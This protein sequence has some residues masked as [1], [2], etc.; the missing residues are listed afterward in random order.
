MKRE[1]MKQRK[2]QSIN[3]Q[4]AHWY[5]CI[6]VLLLRSSLQAQT[7]AKQKHMHVGKRVKKMHTTHTKTTLASKRHMYVISAHTQ[8]PYKGEFVLVS[9]G[10]VD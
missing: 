10:A 2:A 4:R 3:P 7:P 1:K 6:Y 8:C 5:T 9:L